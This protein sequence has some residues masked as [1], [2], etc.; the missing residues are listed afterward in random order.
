MKTEIIVFLHSFSYCEDLEKVVVNEGVTEI[1]DSAFS[2]CS[3]LTSLTLPS[4]LK[5]IGEYTFSNCGLKELT[6]PASVE[7]IGT[8]AFS[9]SENIEKVNIGNNVKIGYDAFL[10]CTNL[11]DE[12]G[13]VVINGVFCGTKHS[14]NSETKKYDPIYISKNVTDIATSV[15]ESE[16]Q[17]VVIDDANKNFSLE[18]GSLYSK[19]G[20]IWFGLVD[21][22]AVFNEKEDVYKQ[23][24]IVL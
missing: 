15:L 11:A 8:Y 13:S 7:E 2:G 10:G 14:Y 16:F 22:T 17:D 23:S 1:S 21:K 19:D 20:K 6:L 12:H 24:N 5:Y 9:Y 4:T 3:K 18:D